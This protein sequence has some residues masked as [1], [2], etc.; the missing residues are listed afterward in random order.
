[1]RVRLSSEAPAAPAAYQTNA[2]IVRLAADGSH[3]AIVKQLKDALD[4]R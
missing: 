4:K 2:G 1:L 3:A